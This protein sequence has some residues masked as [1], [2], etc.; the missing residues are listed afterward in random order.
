MYKNIG[1]KIKF[2]AA[3]VG[4]LGVIGSIIIGIVI[5]TLLDD[6]YLTSDVSYLGI[7]IGIVSALICWVSQY[8]IYGFGELVDNSTQI[9]KKLSYSSSEN[10]MSEKIEKLK[11]WRT[12]GLITEEEYLEKINSL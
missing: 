9:N 5:T 4:Y 6:N 11:E 8:I 3:L 10:D 1:K 2:F 7:I 12:K